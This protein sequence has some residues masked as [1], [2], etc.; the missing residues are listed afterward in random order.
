MSAD[1]DDLAL[2]ACTSSAG[3]RWPYVQGAA[4]PSGLFRASCRCLQ[5]GCIPSARPPAAW[6]C[7]QCGCIP[8]AGP[9]S[10][11]MVFFASRQTIQLVFDYNGRERRPSSPGLALSCKSA[12]HPRHT[13]SGNHVIVACPSSFAVSAL[14]VPLSC[15]VACSPSRWAS[16]SRQEGLRCISLC[17]HASTSTRVDG[18]M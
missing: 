9:E 12:M 15:I 1:D 3:F 4:A 7:I 17:S 18:E 16:C 13:S 11:I 2:E 5:C 8:S 6:Q 14:H 10:L